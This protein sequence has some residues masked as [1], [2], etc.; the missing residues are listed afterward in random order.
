MDIQYQIIFILAGNQTTAKHAFF[1]ILHE[2]MKLFKSLTVIK[3]SLLCNIF[4]FSCS[5]QIE[6]NK[7]NADMQEPN[8]VA[9][10]KTSSDEGRNE[11]LDPNGFFV[12]FEQFMFN[13]DFQ[14]ERVKFPIV[15]NGSKI[16]DVK[17]W[18]NQDLYKYQEFIPAL[19][20]DTLDGF[21]SNPLETKIDLY[22]PD[23]RKQKAKKYGFKKIDN[24]WYLTGVEPTKI[25]DLP[26]QEFVNFLV[27]F[28]TDSIFQKQHIR[29]PMKDSFLSDEYEIE[30]KLI[31]SADWQFMK[32]ADGINNLM[33]L[34]IINSKSSYRTIVYR[35]NENGI[36]CQSFFVKKNDAWF[37]YEMS[38]FSM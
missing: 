30:S 13:E 9:P 25:T 19:F 12:F 38:D 33:V 18:R 31:H 3:I 14:R 15:V 8:L 7:S 24:L 22:I 21:F 26:D 32:M 16:D 34:S 4:L 2:N 6:H 11:I 29:F 36:F 27:Q 37:L 23:F 35:G 10:N 5:F 17:Q 28:S 20:S 1:I